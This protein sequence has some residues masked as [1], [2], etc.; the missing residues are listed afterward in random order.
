[1]PTA[2]TYYTGFKVNSG[3]SGVRDSRSPRFHNDQTF[4]RL[5]EAV[6]TVSVPASML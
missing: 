4:W 5:C 2:F 1:V 6:R 3:A